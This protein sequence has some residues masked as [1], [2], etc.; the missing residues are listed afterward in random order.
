ML[1][2]AAVVPPIVTELL[3]EVALNAPAVAVIGAAELVSRVVSARR[4]TDVAAVTPF[5]RLIVVP[6][7]V[8]ETLETVEVMVALVG[9]VMAAEPEITTA[10]PPLI[11]PVGATEVPPEMV[12]VV[13]AVA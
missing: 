9:F 5:V 2:P 7:E 13:P 10:P 8:M 3:V 1:V 12:N 11:A 6:V 4:E